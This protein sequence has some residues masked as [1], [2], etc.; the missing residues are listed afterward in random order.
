MVVESTI[1]AVLR[2]ACNHMT[3]RTATCQ[4]PGHTPDLTI[5]RTP[6]FYIQSCPAC[7][8]RYGFAVRSPR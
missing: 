3:T 7:G 1:D 4:H 8:H 6:G 5:T 2:L